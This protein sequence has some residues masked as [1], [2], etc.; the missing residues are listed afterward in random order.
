MC[1]VSAINIVRSCHEKKL[2]EVDDMAEAPE[3]LF[4]PVYPRQRAHYLGLVIGS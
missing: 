2:K 3:S 4:D 1:D